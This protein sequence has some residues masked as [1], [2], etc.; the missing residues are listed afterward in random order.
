MP[1]LRRYEELARGLE[2]AEALEAVAKLALQRR[3][4]VG[5]EG[6]E[7][8]EGLGFVAAEEG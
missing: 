7:V 1:A 5:V 2:F 8:P 6:N 4:G 3:G